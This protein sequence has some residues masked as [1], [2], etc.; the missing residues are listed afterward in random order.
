[1]IP[2]ILTKD[3]LH[4]WLRYYHTKDADANEVQMAMLLSMLNNYMGGKQKPKDFIVS[5]NKPTT[6]RDTPQTAYDSFAAMA[7]DFGT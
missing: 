1:M 7:K 5:N 4:G 6:R 3:E 2:Y